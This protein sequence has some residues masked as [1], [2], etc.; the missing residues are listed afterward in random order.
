LRLAAEVRSPDPATKGLERAYETWLRAHFPT[1]FSDKQSGRPI[2]FAFYHHDFWEWVWAVRL[3]TSPQPL[4][5][6]WPRGTGKSVGA[7]LACVAVAARNARRYGLYV[8]GTQDLA[9][10]HVETIASHLEGNAFARSYPL[11][12]QRA[13]SKY[14]ASKGWR[15]NRLRTSAG[16]FVDAIGL[17][18]AARGIK[19]EKERPDFIVL[20][21]VD[22]EGEDET[23][24]DKKIDTITRSILPAGSRDV[25]VLFVQ[26]VVHYESVCARLCG[27]AEEKPGQARFLV[28]RRVSGPHPALKD[29]AWEW[30]DKKPVITSG[31]PTWPEG[32]DFAACQAEI[33]RIGP[34]AFEAEHQHLN[35]QREGSPF[36]HVN[37]ERCELQDV[38]AQDFV[39][40]STWCDPAITSNDRSD[41]NGIV[42]EA[43]TADKVLYVLYAWEEKSSPTE[44]IKQAILASRQYG[45]RVLGVETDQ[46]GETWESVYREAVRDLRESGELGE[47]DWVPRF[48]EAK[49]GSSQMSKMHRWQQMV[50]DYERAADA[51]SRRI[52]HVE[53]YAGILERAMLRVPRKKPYDLM[54]AHWHAWNYLVANPVPLGV[55]AQG[56]VRAPHWAAG[57]HTPSEREVK[58]Y[59]VA[60]PTGALF[61]PRV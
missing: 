49:A 45:A 52:V 16:F 11:V 13:L 22:D 34:T 1:Y 54:D 38:P 37:F 27:L 59:G 58:K 47:H 6:V 18:V 24:V 40:C 42:V 43:V 36:A 12:A 4:V 30:R 9:D 55:L 53:P 28:N 46:G 31:T 15:R 21:D 50:P 48:A 61:V 25:A 26:N 2:P 57:V 51:A 19:V 33:E 56:I 39:R 23:A 41:S 5:A 10:R 60:T 35:V 17:D 44:T 7:E 29:F 20:D 32:F 8:S 3:G 14:G